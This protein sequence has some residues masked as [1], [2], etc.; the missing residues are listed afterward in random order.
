MK[1]YRPHRFPPLSVSTASSSALAPM[2]ASVAD[3]FQQGMAQ[4]YAQGHA[5][6]LADGRNQGLGEGR[7]EGLRQGADEGRRA[8]EQSFENVARPVD[9]VLAELNRL[10]AEYQLAQRK[11]VV[12]L[13]AR[14][15][16]QVIRCE[17]TLQPTQLLTLVDEALAAMPPTREQ[18]EVF[19][20][21][22]DLQRIRD[23][24]PERAQRWSLLPDARLETGECHVRAG[25]HE[26]DAGCQQRLAACMQQVASQLVDG[27][28]SHLQVVP[29][30]LQEAA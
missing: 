2:Q 15:A 10:H 30:P 7:S 16:R 8:A 24:D 29:Q 25:D 20:N 22:E 17:L 9:A 14:V 27:Q 6:G 1:T 23:L 26:A 12:D 18:I 4:G 11:E 28:G 3:G 5:S 21:P 19:L 13:V